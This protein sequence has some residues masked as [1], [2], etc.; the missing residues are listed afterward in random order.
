MVIELASNSAACSESCLFGSFIDLDSTA[1]MLAASWMPEPVA[2]V[3]LTAAAIFFFA[4]HSK[5][6]LH[7][8]MI[9]R[10]YG[11]GGKKIP[12]GQKMRD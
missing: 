9:R 10:I 12:G 1:A 6:R 2:I 7:E 8:D 5:Q 3:L 11:P 4:T